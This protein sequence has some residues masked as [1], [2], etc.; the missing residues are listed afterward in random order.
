[1]SIGL[2]N[3]ASAMMTRLAEVDT[4]AHNLANSPTPGYRAMRVSFRSFRETFLQTAQGTGNQPPARLP[5]GVTVHHQR[6][7]LRT[8]T[9]RYTGNLLDVA[10][11]G[12]GWFVVQTPQG[13]R[14]TR[15]GNFALSPNGNLVTA[16]GYPVLGVNGRPIAIGNRG[17]VLIAENGEISVGTQTVGRLQIVRFADP[18]IVRPVG[19]GYYVGSSPQP[20]QAKVKQGYLELS[21]V[22]TVTELVRLLNALRHYEMAA[23]AL[24]ANQTTGQ[25]LMEATR[26]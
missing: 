17:E 10:V 25:A 14:Y 4:I 22:Q 23:R 1:M 13:V 18:N 9:M 20:S 21:N 7:D 16:D 19:N 11:D 26:A 8:G 15:K 6:L 24:A 12:D 3:A 5:L 2:Y